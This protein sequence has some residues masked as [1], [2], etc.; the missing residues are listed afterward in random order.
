MGVGAFRFRGCGFLVQLLLEGRGFLSRER[1]FW[2]PS[3]QDSSMRNSMN[4]DSN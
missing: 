3:Y 4:S 1:E 2:H